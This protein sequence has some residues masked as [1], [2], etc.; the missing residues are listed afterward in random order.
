MNEISLNQ[1]SNTGTSD[2]TC[3]SCN[4]GYY[5]N[6]ADHTCVAHGCVT[7]TS[8]TACASCVDQELRTSDTNC[9]TCNAGHYLS[10]QV[11]VAYGCQKENEYECR[12]CVDQEYRVDS[13]SC[14]ACFPGYYLDGLDCRPYDCVS[15]TSGAG[16]A[17][18]VNQTSRTNNETCASCNRGYELNVQDHTCEP[19]VVLSNV[20]SLSILLLK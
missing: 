10:G 17:S 20:D 6:N 11:C 15:T 18:C 14:N 8:G 9:L 1:R 4:D 3:S 13:T 5:L 16:C 2:A 7:D 19:Y 12:T